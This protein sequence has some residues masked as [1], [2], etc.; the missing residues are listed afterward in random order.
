MQP[1]NNTL[2][3]LHVKD[4]LNRLC[5]RRS[6]SRPVIRNNM[7]LKFNRVKLEYGD[8]RIFPASELKKNFYEGLK[9][10]R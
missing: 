9:V 10:I 3:S 2:F 7:I 8:S 5:L 6:W 4:I 1:N